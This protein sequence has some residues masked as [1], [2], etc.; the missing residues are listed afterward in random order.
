MGETDYFYIQPVRGSAMK[1]R[2]GFCYVLLTACFYNVRLTQG[3]ARRGTTT[4]VTTA[5]S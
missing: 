4:R 2:T 3:N 5:I 1:S